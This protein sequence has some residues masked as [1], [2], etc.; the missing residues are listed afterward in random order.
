MTLSVAANNQGPAIF[1]K[2]YI[3][4]W[5]YIWQ[6]KID[7]AHKES[8]ECLRVAEE[9]GD[10]YYQT[11]AYISY[12]S[13]SYVKGD[14]DKAESYLLQALAFSEKTGHYTNWMT[15]CQY[16]FEL[17]ISRAKYKEALNYYERMISILEPTKYRLS[18][19]G[20]YKVGLARARV[21]NSDQDIDLSEVLKYYSDIRSKA[22]KHRC[23][24]YICEILLNVDLH[25]DKA[26]DWIKKAIETDKKNGFMF[27]LGQDYILYS[28]LFQRKG[29][30]SKARENFI[31]AIEIFK[32]C[33]ADG[34]VEKYEKELTSLT[35]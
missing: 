11:P 15:A 29:D 8:S 21:L 22:M 18:E 1:L 7:L 31:K 28:E 23:S 3:V 13:L 12:G 5:F 14:F 20:L 10:I 2:S 16:I 25:I 26:E 33:G 30:L 32:D 35:P 27:F 24:R 34:W 17:Y 6:G 9:S 4:T 19:I